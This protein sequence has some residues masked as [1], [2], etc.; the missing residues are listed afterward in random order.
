MWAW[1]LTKLIPVEKVVVDTRKIKEQESLL[2]EK[3]HR[4]RPCRKQV[5]KCPLSSPQKTQHQQQRTFTP[6]DLTEFQTRKVYIDT[7]SLKTMKRNWR[8]R[9]QEEFLDGMGGIQTDQVCG[10]RAVRPGRVA[11][12][13]GGG[14]AVQQRPQY[15]P[16]SRLHC[17]QTAW[18]AAVGQRPM[19]FTTNGLKTYFWDDQTGPQRE[20]YCVFNQDDLQK[21]MNR[22]QARKDLLTVSIDDKI[23]DRYCKKRQSG[24]YVSRLVRA[25]GSTCW[26]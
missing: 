20:V 13:C 7:G 2:G 14:Q 1:G 10:L 3:T 6:E 9:R 16:R 12:S 4:V 17:T 11:A 21:L 19:I 15:R 25:S 26:S 24:L 18:E 8:H 23:T 5:K 22:R